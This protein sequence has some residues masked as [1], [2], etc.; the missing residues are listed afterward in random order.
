M[1]EQGIKGS[2]CLLNTKTKTTTPFL[3]GKSPKACAYAPCNARHKAPSLLDNVIMPFYEPITCAP[4]A[5]TIACL[6]WF[7]RAAGWRSTCWCHE[8]NNVGS[9]N[10]SLVPPCNWISYNLPT[11]GA[12]QCNRYRN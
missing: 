5:L 2:L 3:F 11:V 7:D 4:S 9:E 10:L 1:L 12:G 6:D 8:Q